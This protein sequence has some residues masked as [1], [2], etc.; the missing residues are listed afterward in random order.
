ME[1]ETYVLN[2]LLVSEN[3]VSEQ[4]GK[5]PFVYAQEVILLSLVLKALELNSAEHWLVQLF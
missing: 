3:R 5:I 4:V 2:H 1:M